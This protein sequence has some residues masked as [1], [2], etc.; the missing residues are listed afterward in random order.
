[1]HFT[2]TRKTG[3]TFVELLIVLTLIATMSA[4]ALPSLLSRYAAESLRAAGIGP[5]QRELERCRQ[6]AIDHGATT[7]FIVD[8]SGSQFSWQALDKSCPL[9]V[10]TF[11]NGLMANAENG[12]ATRRGVAELL[13]HADGTAS[14]AQFVVAGHS[15]RWRVTVERLTGLVS[16][17]RL[18]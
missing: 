16:I 2:V 11:S 14:P 15:I 10:G 17:E 7:Q 9:Q 5:L 3:F 8:S 1:M 12:K 18:P 6:Y 4:I 13:F